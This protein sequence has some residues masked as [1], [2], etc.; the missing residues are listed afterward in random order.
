MRRL[1]LALSL[2]EVESVQSIL[3]EAGAE[4]SLSCD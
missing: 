1:L 2:E 3:E 4:V